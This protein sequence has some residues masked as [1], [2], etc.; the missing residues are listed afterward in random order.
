MAVVNTS[1]ISSLTITDCFDIAKKMFSRVEAPQTVHDEFTAAF[2]PP[3]G[4]IVRT[5]S[6]SQK[7]RARALGVGRGES[8]AIILANDLRTPL[9]IDDRQARKVAK[10][11]Q[12]LVIGSVQLLKL[13]FEDCL[14]QRGE[15]EERLRRFQRTDRADAATIERALRA[16]KSVSPVN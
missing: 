3:P 13:A 4:L 6:P 8:E 14:L 5:L 16:Q 1:A 7:S 11:H 9:I 15:F 2:R 10:K 12:I